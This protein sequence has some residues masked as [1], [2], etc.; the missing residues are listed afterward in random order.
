MP[1]FLCQE[2]PL[3]W[4][5]KEHPVTCPLAFGGCAFKFPPV[6]SRLGPAGELECPCQCRD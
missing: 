2:L 1:S 4:G 3:T 6:S 5:V